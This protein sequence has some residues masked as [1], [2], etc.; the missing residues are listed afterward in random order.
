MIS[1]DSHFI[2]NSANPDQHLIT[3]LLTIGA[4]AEV[5]NTDFKLVDTRLVILHL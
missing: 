5:K 2:F 1:L 3:N 4:M